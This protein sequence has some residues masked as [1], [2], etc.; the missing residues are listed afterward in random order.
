MDDQE[1]QAVRALVFRAILAGILGMLVG[2]GSIELMKLAGGRFDSYATI[3]WVPWLVVV[4]MFLPMAYRMGRET[5]RN[6]S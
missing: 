6:A 3:I 4:V 1:K 5:E 2:I